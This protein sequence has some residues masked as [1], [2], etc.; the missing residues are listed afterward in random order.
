MRPKGPA[1]APARPAQQ[2]LTPAD[3]GLL[4][5][6]RRDGRAGLTDLAAAT[7]WSSATAARRLAD[8]RAGGALFFDIDLDAT[9]LGVTTQAML[10]MA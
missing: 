3:A 5:A 4:A 8:L 7:G 1:I 10:W 2:A 9:L 6:L